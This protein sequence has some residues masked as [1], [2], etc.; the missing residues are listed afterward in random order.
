[1][2]ARVAAAFLL[3][4]ATC[5][6]VL[7]TLRSPAPSPVMHS[8]PL[9][10]AVAALPL[11]NQVPTIVVQIVQPPSAASAPLPVQTAT[12]AQAFIPFVSSLPEPFDGFVGPPLPPGFSRRADPELPAGTPIIQPGSI[13]TTITPVVIH[14]PTSPDIVI[15]AALD[16]AEKARKADQRARPHLPAESAP[17]RGVLINLNTATQAELETL[18]AVGPATALRIIEYRE[19]HGPFRRIEDLDKIK[20]IGEETIAKLAPLVTI[21]SVGP[22]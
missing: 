15:D 18:P 12:V 2:F 6:A 17:A 22:R 3:G 20:G 9:Q 14:H 21:G 10:Q 8:P 16:G 5:G 7:Y 4:G 1:M 13:V 11:A 19:K